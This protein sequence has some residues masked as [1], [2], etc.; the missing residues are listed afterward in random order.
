MDATLREEKAD[1]P[2]KGQLNGNFSCKRRKLYHQA[3][4]KR[5][6]DFKRDW[7]SITTST[8]SLNPS[9]N[10]RQSFCEKVFSH[11]YFQ[12]TLCCP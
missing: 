11:H 2:A 9:R 7:K 10:L 12:T 4:V 1:G 6:E 3:G 8:Q 5:R